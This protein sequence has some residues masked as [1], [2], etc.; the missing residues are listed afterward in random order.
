[1]LIVD[2]GQCVRPISE[3]WRVEGPFDRRR[4][5]AEVLKRMGIRFIVTNKSTWDEEAIRSEPGAWGMRK[6]LA[7]RDSTLYEIEP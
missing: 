6:V 1:M 5:S 2:H 3:T 4:E 7:A